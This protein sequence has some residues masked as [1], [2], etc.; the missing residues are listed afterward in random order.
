MAHRLYVITAHSTREAQPLSAL[1]YQD[2]M[3]KNIW[4][5]SDKYNLRSMTNDI[6]DH[7]I[8]YLTQIKAKYRG[9]V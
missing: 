4:C 6:L 5:S 2:V 7:V 9:S 3:K 8:I 1:R